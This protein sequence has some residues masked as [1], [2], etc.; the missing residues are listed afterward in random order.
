MKTL[1]RS[2]DYSELQ[3]SGTALA[4]RSINPKVDILGSTF[5]TGRGAFL[6]TNDHFCLSVTV[7]KFHCTLHHISIF[8]DHCKYCSYGQQSELTKYV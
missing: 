7:I 2:N 1:S 4:L 8:Y 3:P 6:T 5:S